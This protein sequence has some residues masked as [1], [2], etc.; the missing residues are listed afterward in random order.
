MSTIRGAVHFYANQLSDRKNQYELKVKVYFELLDTVYLLKSANESI[1]AYLEDKPDFKDITSEILKPSK[2]KVIE[3]REILRSLSQIA[4]KLQF[5]SSRD[6]F[7][8]YLEF[9]R[10]S[11]EPEEDSKIFTDK[12]VKLTQAIRKDL[13]KRNEPLFHIPQT[14]E[15]NRGYSGK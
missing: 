4:A 2:D 12:L 11:I 10:D 13:M 1:N 15:K 7:E 8:A 9:Y 5:V 3:Y 14:K 6:V